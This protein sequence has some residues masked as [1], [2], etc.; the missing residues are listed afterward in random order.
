MTDHVTR[1]LVDLRSEAFASRLRRRHTA[2]KRLRLFGVAAI[3]VA[4]GMLAFLVSSIVI[5]GYRVFYQTRIRLEIFFDPETIAPSGSYDSQELARGYY[6]A[7]I[8]GST[9]DIFNHPRDERTR[10]YV[11]GLYG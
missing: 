3:C 4:L 11:K 8:V 1:R 7:L 9:Y 10:D 2:A 5:Q 6:G